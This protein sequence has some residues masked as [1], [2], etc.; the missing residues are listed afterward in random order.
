MA[1]TGQKVGRVKHPLIIWLI[2]HKNACVTSN[3]PPSGILAI[4]S[5]TRVVIKGED[6]TNS[7]TK[8]FNCKFVLLFLWR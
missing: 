7:D 1:W 5:G 3:N 8:Y 4:G 6:G 2:A